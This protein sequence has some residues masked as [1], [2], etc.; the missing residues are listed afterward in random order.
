[1]VIF[2]D[3]RLL[4]ILYYVDSMLLGRYCFHVVG[5]NSHD[6][7]LQYFLRFADQIRD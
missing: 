4:S 3:E 5:L 6:I 1:M 2:C 7:C